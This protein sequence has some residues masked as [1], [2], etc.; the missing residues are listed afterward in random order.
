[1]ANNK[2]ETRKQIAAG[3]DLPV[4]G[5]ISWAKK[6][7][8]EVVVS[9]GDLSAIAEEFR[10]LRTNISFLDGLPNKVLLVTSYMAGEGKTF[11]S[12]NLAN[13]FAI[14]QKK[15]VLVELD[16]RTP[17][18]LEKSKE[19]VTPG[20]T[21]YLTRDLQPSQIIQSLNKCEHLHFIASGPQLKNAG[22]LI[23]SDRIRQLFDYLREHFDYV[24]VDCSSVGKVSDALIISKL[25][26]LTLFTIRPGFSL[27]T[28]LIK[29]NELSKK[30][31]HSFLV[32][33]GIHSGNGYQ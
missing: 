17:N 16:L 13:A 4:M 31:S 5:E 8:H 26:D 30:F 28:S 27:Q 10:G 23:L 2:T 9:A 22:E 15:V 14:S 7:S 19:N 12:L 6:S 21:D 20:I 29:L 32:I 25:I 1:V 11:I 24:V 18:P 3:T 33:N